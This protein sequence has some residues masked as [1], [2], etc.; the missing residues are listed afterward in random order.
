MATHIVLLRGINV[1]SANRIG[2]PE[3]RE[4]LTG[5]GFTRVQTHLQSGNVLLD[6][7]ADAIVPAVREVIDVPCVVRSVAELDAVIAD[8]PFWEKAAE[9]PKVFQVTFRDQLLEPAAFEALTTR[10]GEGE[11]VAAHGREI[12]SYHPH[13]IARSKLALAVV[14]AKQAA[15][16]R[17]WNCVLKLAELAHARVS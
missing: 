1:G 17:N 8:N 9:N 14:P 7:D 10:A 11:F 15:T 2:M 12:Y 13:G 3:L 4:A 6:G 16:A 5:A